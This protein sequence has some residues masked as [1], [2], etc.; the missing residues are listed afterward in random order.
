MN[1]GEEDLDAGALAGFAAV[2]LR[3]AELQ[4]VAPAT[5]K[6]TIKRYFTVYIIRTLGS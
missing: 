2:V 3:F 4:L 6:H 5:T 1:R